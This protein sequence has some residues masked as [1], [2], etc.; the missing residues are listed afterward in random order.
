ME[1]R[2]YWGGEGYF[3]VGKDGGCIG[4]VHSLSG[5]H[6]REAVL[7]GE[8]GFF[9]IQIPIFPKERER[10]REVENGVR[11]RREKKERWV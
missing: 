8:R 3:N 10:K 2:S 11:D 7:L 6:Y 4:R 1:G 9:L 5:A